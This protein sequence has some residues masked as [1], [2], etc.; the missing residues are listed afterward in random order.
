[1]Q[2]QPCV[3][4][5]K[6]AYALRKALGGD[7]SLCM[8]HI[9]STLTE[10]YG[11]GDEFFDGSVK[12]AQGSLDENVG[13]LVRRFSP[14]I[15]H[16]HN[17]PDLLTISAT[18]VVA[19]IPII[20]DTHEAL[21]LRQTGYYVRDGP[22][23]IAKYGDYEKA[24]NERS[25]GRIYVSEGVRDH[26]Q[27]RCSTNPDKDLVFHNYVCESIF[28]QCVRRKRS[29]IDGSTHIVYIGTLSDQQGDHY[30]LLEI[31]REIADKGMHIHIYVT[32]ENQA[33]KELGDASSFIHYHGHLDRIALLDELTEYDY[34]WLGLNEARNK[35]HVD[36]A[37]PNKTLEYIS[38]GLPIL[39]FPHKT[40]GGFIEEHNV[41][42]VFKDADELSELVQD[43]DIEKLR[44]NTA[45]IRYQYTIERNIPRLLQF[46][47]KIIEGEKA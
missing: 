47:A 35:P 2:P 17:A 20:H 8:G 26:I 30:N 29:A 1:L 4:A 32:R 38:C 6:Y 21:S 43:A 40:I 22:E 3:R 12:L 41:G 37:F 42:L 27:G 15:I 5:L 13:E 33:Y 45:R 10:L 18:R 25:D 39:S 11:H 9:H 19:D 23:E 7:V 14:D 16:S 46:Y 44:D 34:G 28:P 24:A 31:F 36:V